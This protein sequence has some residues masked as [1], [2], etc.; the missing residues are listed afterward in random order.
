MKLF[1]H[2]MKELHLQEMQ[3]QNHQEHAS[4]YLTTKFH[5]KDTPDQ[6]QK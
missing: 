1:F 2:Y 5:N 4:E 3:H 6:I